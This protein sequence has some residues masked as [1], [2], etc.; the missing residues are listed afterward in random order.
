MSLLP[1]VKQYDY[2][3]DSVQLKDFQTLKGNSLS[4]V[5]LRQLKSRIPGLRIVKDEKSVSQN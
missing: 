4:S 2:S 1:E 5:L 3:G